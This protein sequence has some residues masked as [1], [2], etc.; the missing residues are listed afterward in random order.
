[1]IR[2][3]GHYYETFV[4]GRFLFIW[5][6]QHLNFYFSYRSHITDVLLGNIVTRGNTSTSTNTYVLSSGEVDDLSLF[7]RK[8]S[9]SETTLFQSRKKLKISNILNISIPKQFVRLGQM[10]FISFM[11]AINVI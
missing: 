1:M 3:D 10:T 5:F 4:D 9:F 11:F 8:W 2:I 7:A 6:T